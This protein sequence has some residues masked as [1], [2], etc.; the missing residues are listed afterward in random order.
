MKIDFTNKT[1]VV[2]GGTRG[3]GAAIVQLFQECNAEIIAT[4][5]NL[6][7]LKRLNEKSSDKRTKYTHL[8]FISDDSVQNFLGY[9]EKLGRIDVLINNAGVN[10][11]DSIH[12][13]S[14]NDWDW[15]N[16]VNLRGPFLITRSVSK[17][18][19]K[20][21]YGKIVNIASV[22][23]IVSRAK[24]A[25]YSTTKWGLVGFT[26]AIAHDLAPHN[27]LV[28]AV[29]PGFVDTELTRRI[30]GEKEIEK[31]VSSIP[32]KRLADAGEIAKAILFL[33]SDHNT[34]ITGQ[35]IIVDGG[36]TSA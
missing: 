32:Q 25:A 24:R 31:L 18:M 7:N 8:D 29:S 4:G 14:K 6:D 23:S 26:K 19:K 10:K 2:T 36:F 28:N 22:F 12:E 20:Q 5:T 16:E 34:Y 17:I 33:T 30:L 9:I 1:V 15:M 27:I 11:I 35:N 3:V 13:I 21:G